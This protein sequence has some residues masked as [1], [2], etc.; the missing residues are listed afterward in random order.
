MGHIYSGSV[1]V[2]YPSPVHATHVNGRQPGHGMGHEA[3]YVMT[4]IPL[5]SPED[6]KVLIKE[7]IYVV[8]PSEEADSEYAALLFRLAL[9]EHGP[10]GSYL[11]LGLSPG[12]RYHMCLRD[13]VLT[14]PDSTHDSTS[15]P[16]ASFTLRSWPALTRFPFQA[17][18][19]LTPRQRWLN[20]SK[21]YINQ[22]KS[23]VKPAR[24]ILGHHDPHG[25][26]NCRH[27]PEVQS[28]GDG[29]VLIRLHRRPRK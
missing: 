2:G 29:G 27:L 17:H 11:L 16:H 9:G 13:I 4:C 22:P 25:T 19:I 28:M 20:S 1:S 21:R 24:I 18:E 7:A 5:P 8:T 14:Q 10:T 3:I 6:L 15:G 23:E 12:S 26:P